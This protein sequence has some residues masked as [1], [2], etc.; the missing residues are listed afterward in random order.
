M[1]IIILGVHYNPFASFKY[2]FGVSTGTHVGLLWGPASAL[3][4]DSA[5]LEGRMWEV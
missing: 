3:P 2:L 1:I 4:Q 5:S